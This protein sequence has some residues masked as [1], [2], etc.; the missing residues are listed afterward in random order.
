[1]STPVAV[2]HVPAFASTADGMFDMMTL[3]SD[4]FVDRQTALCG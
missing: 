1:M 3:I 2:K 4:G